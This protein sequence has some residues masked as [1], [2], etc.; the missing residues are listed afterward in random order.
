MLPPL[1]KVQSD[2]RM[3]GESREGTLRGVIHPFVGGTGGA[4]LAQFVRRE[5]VVVYDVKVRVFRIADRNFLVVF[6][7][8]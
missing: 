3:V 1:L 8:C 2:G 6:C 7:P 5:C 4:K